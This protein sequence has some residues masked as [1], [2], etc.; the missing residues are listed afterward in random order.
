MLNSAYIEPKFEYQDFDFDDYPN[1]YLVVTFGRELLEMKKIGFYS[2]QTEVAVTFAEKYHGDVMYFYI[3]DKVPLSFGSGS[4][5]FVMDNSK[6]IYV[7]KSDLAIN[8]IEGK[9]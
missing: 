1:N 2:G 7:G 3:M 4:E 8:E 9:K 5:F 6:K